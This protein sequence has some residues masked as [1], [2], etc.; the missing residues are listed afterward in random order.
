M[1]LNYVGPTQFFTKSQ[2]Q[3]ILITTSFELV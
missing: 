3:D 2:A 1:N